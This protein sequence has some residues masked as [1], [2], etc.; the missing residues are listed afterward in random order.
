MKPSKATLLNRLF[1]IT[2]MLL[3]SMVLCINS[4]ALAGVDLEVPIEMVDHGLRAAQDVAG[5]TNM[6]RSRIFLDPA[7]YEGDT[8][9]YYFV[10]NTSL[11]TKLLTGFLVMGFVVTCVLRIHGRSVTS[12]AKK[13]IV[14]FS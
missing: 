12:G 11:A 7:A 9:N 5:T 3:L 1:F 4:Q 2:P 6:N 14:Y 10:L 13:Q 8:V